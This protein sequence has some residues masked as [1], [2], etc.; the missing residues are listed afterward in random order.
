MPFEV[1]S[2]LFRHGLTTGGGVLVSIDLIDATQAEAFVGA[3]MVLAG[4][5]WSITRKWLRKQRT[6]SAS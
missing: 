5:A 4:I 2:A 3:G 6:G 1:I